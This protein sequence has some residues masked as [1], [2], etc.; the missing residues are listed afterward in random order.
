MTLKINIYQDKDPPEI[1]TPLEEESCG[2]AIRSL[3]CMSIYTVKSSKS[4]ILQVQS[5]CAIFGL[6]HN[7]FFIVTEVSSLNSTQSESGFSESTLLDGGLKRRE[8]VL[9]LDNSGEFKFDSKNPYVSREISSKNFVVAR[10]RKLWKC[11]K[12]AHMYVNLCC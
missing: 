4:T 1:S 5:V 7:T 6:S 8:L 11:D 3:T 12:I 10:R 9:V 2:T